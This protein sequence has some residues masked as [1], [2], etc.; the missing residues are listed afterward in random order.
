VLANWEMPVKILILAF[1]GTVSCI[2]TFTLHLQSFDFETA[3]TLSKIVDTV[4]ESKNE[5]TGVCRYFSEQT[6]VAFN[7]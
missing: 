6:G 1:L 3:A 4:I 7:A 2:L 5:L